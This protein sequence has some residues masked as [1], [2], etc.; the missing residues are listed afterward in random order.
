MDYP[1]HITAVI[2]F[3]G[4]NF[5]CAYCHNR[6][7]LSFEDGGIEAG[8][9]LEKLYKRRAFLD[10]VTFSGG[11][12]CLQ[13]Q[14]ELSCF[15]KE[16]KDLGFKIKLDTNGSR[17]K[18]LKAMLPLVDYVAMDI[19]CSPKDYC[20]LT[21]V[22]EDIFAEVA[23]SINLLK[24]GAFLENRFLAEFRTTVLPN[25]TL[26]DIETIARLIE[27]KSASYYL[28]QVRKTEN[29]KETPKEIS[30]FVKAKEIA[31]KFIPT[32]L[33]GVL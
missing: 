8:E 10:A 11:E 26:S 24:E 22:K 28:Q 7:L 32:F 33:R 1:K 6:E 27:S 3:G 31:D 2:F 30:F 18:C 25:F 21:C 9:I 12:P 16:I 13:K 4:C 5:N 23:E 20:A 29:Y 14:E 15:A 19:K 17:P